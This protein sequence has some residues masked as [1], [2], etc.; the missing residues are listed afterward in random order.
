[1]HKTGSKGASFFLFPVIRKKIVH[2]K[3]KMNVMLFFALLLS[4]LTNA[5]AQTPPVCKP[6]SCGPGNTKTEE[7]AVITD[8]RKEVEFVMA[9]MA[10]SKIAFDKDVTGFQIPK[11]SSDEE[12][13][14]FLSQTLGML[15]GEMRFKIPSEK[16]SADF[17]NYNPKPVKSKQ[18]LLVNLKKETALL[19]A[20]VQ[21]L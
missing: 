7:A 19:K 2:M 21:K 6:S 11:G 17:I 13:L 4:G 20:Q 8:L 12:S 18:E 1:M 14:L 5:L 15:R 16:V 9:K 3:K 10:E